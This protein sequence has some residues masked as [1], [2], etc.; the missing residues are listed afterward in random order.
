MLLVDGTRN[1]PVWLEYALPVIS[2][3]FGKTVLVLTLELVAGSSV[4]VVLGGIVIGV[5]FIGG[6]LVFVVAGM[7]RSVAAIGVMIPC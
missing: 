3:I 5:T 2:R 1:L 7:T 6:L 4:V